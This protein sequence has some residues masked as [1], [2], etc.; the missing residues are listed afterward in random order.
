MT[1]TEIAKKLHAGEEWCG[2]GGPKEEDGGRTMT[3]GHSTKMN[4]AQHVE[5]VA[6][7]NENHETVSLFTCN[8]LNCLHM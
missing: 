1:Q 4:S 3:L 6:E 2:W 7:T 8:Y 5:R